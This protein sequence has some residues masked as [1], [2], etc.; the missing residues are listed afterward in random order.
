MKLFLSEYSVEEVK[1]LDEESR[2]VVARR[3]K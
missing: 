3:E 1:V 2:L